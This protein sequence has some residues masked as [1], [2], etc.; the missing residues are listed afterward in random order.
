MH[1]NIAWRISGWEGVPG[2]ATS[3]L[4]PFLRR[5][6]LLMLDRLI[7]LATETTPALCA[8]Y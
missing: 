8:L 7:C 2:Y 1:N 4:E 3:S 6:N 5:F